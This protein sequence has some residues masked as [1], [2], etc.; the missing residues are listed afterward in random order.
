LKPFN[1]IYHDTLEIQNLGHTIILLFFL[2]CFNEYFW[3]LGYDLKNWKNGYDFSC[4]FFD[5]FVFLYVYLM[6]FFNGF[7]FLI[8]LKFCLISLYFLI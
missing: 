3:F 5:F 8:F 6:I 2:S 7:L 4:V 1:G